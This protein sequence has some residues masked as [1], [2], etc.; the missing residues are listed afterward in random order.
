MCSLLHDAV[1]QYRCRCDFEE[2]EDAINMITVC[3]RGLSHLK[4]I[5]IRDSR[6]GGILKS[7]PWVPPSLVAF[8]K[9]FPLSQASFNMLLGTGEGDVSPFNGYLNITAALGALKK[10]I[11]SLL[12]YPNPGLFHFGL[13]M[14]DD[15]IKHKTK[16]D[17]EYRLHPSEFYSDCSIAEVKHLHMSI[18]SPFSGAENTANA[19]AMA[20]TFRDLRLL[21]CSTS[22]LENLSLSLDIAASRHTSAIQS[23]SDLLSLTMPLARLHT[24]TLTRFTFNTPTELTKFLIMQ[25]SLR[26]LSLIECVIRNGR[27]HDVLHLLASASFFRLDSINLYRPRDEDN[28][29]HEVDWGNCFIPSVIPNDVIL[30]FINAKDTIKRYNPFH[31]SQRQWRVEDSERYRHLVEDAQL[32]SESQIDLNESLEYEDDSDWAPEDVK[33]WR[34]REAEDADVD[35]PEFDSEYDFSAEEDSESNDDGVIYGEHEWLPKPRQLL[36]KRPRIEGEDELAD[37]LRT[38]LKNLITATTPDGNRTEFE[39]DAVQPLK[40]AVWAERD[41]LRCDVKLNA[42]HVDS[43]DL[44][45][46]AAKGIRVQQTKGSGQ[47]GVIVVHVHLWNGEKEAHEVKETKRTTFV[48]CPFNCGTNSGRQFDNTV[49]THQGSFEGTDIQV[50]VDHT[51]YDQLHKAMEVIDLT[52]GTTYETSG[53]IVINGVPFHPSAAAFGLK[54]ESSST[55]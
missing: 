50:V 28:Y 39:F 3:F 20:Q 54:P 49:C 19:K 7:E 16:S 24:L 38:Q 13:P 42:V 37:R 47:S 12:V 21:R 46:G 45:F 31:K 15:D 48:V 11:E 6:E 36:G 44:L 55:A 51:N 34:W 8:Q 26:H 18:N 29:E 2:S 17:P 33:A 41:T 32:S 9:F 1:N 10:P 22:C 52:E 53:K 23:F 27:W 25:P 14:V 35:G 5:V 4:H 30:D 43:F 40:L